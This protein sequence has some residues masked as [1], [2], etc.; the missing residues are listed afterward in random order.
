M[1]K[2]NKNTGKAKKQIES[3]EN[4]LSDLKKK[5]K[6]QKEALTKIIKHTKK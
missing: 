5:I 6:Q 4:S 2:Q 1:A 3:N